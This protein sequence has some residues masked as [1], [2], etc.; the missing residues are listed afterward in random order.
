MNG[1]Y[2]H[3]RAR[4]ELVHSVARV[5]C[6]PEPSLEPLLGAISHHTE[7]SIRVFPAPARG[8]LLSAMTAYDVGARLYLPSRGKPARRLESAVAANYFKTWWNSKLAPQREFARG[9][10]GLICLAFYEM[11]EVKKHIGYTP[12]AWIEKVTQHRLSV[13]SDAIEKQA[14]K[15]LLPD[16]LGP[17][18]SSTISTKSSNSSNL[19]AS[20]NATENS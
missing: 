10:K 20:L 1:T 3:S 4:R 11:P 9:F 19:G 14:T 17:L 18:P 16:P 15:I 8:A 2:H 5:V 12:E 7:L 6:P 13:Y